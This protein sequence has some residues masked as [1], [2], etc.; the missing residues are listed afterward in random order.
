MFTQK[1]YLTT[2][3]LT[4]KW[5]FFPGGGGEVRL[6]MRN[7]RLCTPSDFDYS[8]YFEIIKYPFLDVHSYSEHRLLPWSRSGELTEEE[9]QLYVT[10]SA[11][12]TSE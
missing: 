1:N 9:R 5:K 8:P 6:F 4:I 3:L 10:S 12:S 7:P 2:F 11:S